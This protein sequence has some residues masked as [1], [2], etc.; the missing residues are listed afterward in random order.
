M[1]LLAAAALFAAAIG[2]G[3]EATDTTP[4]TVSAD[5]DGPRDARRLR[6]N[7]CLAYQLE[8]WKRAATD[9]AV[10]RQPAPPELERYG[11]GELYSETS[12][13][14]AWPTDAAALE[15]L[16]DA[17]RIARAC[18][19]AYCPVLE[20]A[21]FA[22]CG[23]AEVP[24]ADLVAALVALDGAIL[25]RELADP[26]RAAQL[27]ARNRLFRV[28]VEEGP[29]ARGPLDA[30]T[31]VVAMSADGTLILGNRVVDRPELG[32]SLADAHARNPDV[33]VT[34]R[35]DPSIPYAEVVTV[36]DAIRQAGINKV[37]I[38]TS[39]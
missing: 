28:E 37:G 30:P 26:A 7:E 39:K 22:L 1:R 8:Y 4:A 38:S 21:R 31:L 33:A 17:R 18:A 27:A 15:P 23:P 6:A 11:C 13:A 34:I 10:G 25:D 16:R 19:A 20:A 3:R 12:C 9:R 32:R 35:A 24:D 14:R 36:L 5:P 2:C 29:P